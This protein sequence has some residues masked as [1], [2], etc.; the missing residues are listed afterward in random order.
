[1]TGSAPDSPGSTGHA[2]SGAVTVG[3][4]I[5]L[6][7]TTLV[8]FP[9]IAGTLLPEPIVLRN[10]V[11]QLFDWGFV[12]ILVVIV[13]YGE[14]RS[15]RSLGFQPLTGQTLIE[16]LGLTGFFMLGL[17]AWRFLV[18]PWF[19]EL[20]LPAGDPATGSLPPGFYLWFAPFALVTA[21]VAEE[22]IYRG[23]AMQRLLERFESPWPALLLPHI[24]FALY[25]LKD[26][27]ES[28]VSL[29]FLGALFTWY[30]YRTRNLTLL[31]AAHF[32]I[33][34]LAVVGFSVGIR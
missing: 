29:L 28:A 15:L 30:F 14:R 32:M 8:W 20:S 21:S 9:P 6:V 10:V 4:L 27:V 3:L 11:S 18:T 22:I 34:L 5:A 24:A 25:H 2:R 13:L 7:V 17:V 23:Y 26:G 1:M 12:A 19:P 16:A 33:D 31:I